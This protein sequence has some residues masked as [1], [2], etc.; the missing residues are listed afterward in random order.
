MRPRATTRPRLADPA[1]EATGR[2]TTP[3]DSA[4]RSFIVSDLG[5]EFY[6]LLKL[7][8]EHLRFAATWP[9]K[10]HKAAELLGVT[11]DRATALAIADE[12]CEEFTLVPRS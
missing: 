12:I 1:R 11:D 7:T 5:P 2:E 6:R 8:E 9:H 3:H 4:D 10:V